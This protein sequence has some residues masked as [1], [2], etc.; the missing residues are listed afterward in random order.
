MT[1]LAD[2]DKRIELLNILLTPYGLFDDSVNEIV[3]KMSN[4]W[5]FSEDYG[6]LYVFE[7]QPMDFDG[8]QPV[9]DNRSC[10]KRAGIFQGSVKRLV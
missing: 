6:K 8:L 10:R 9:L 5:L 7:N 1:C 4:V 2:S 3:S